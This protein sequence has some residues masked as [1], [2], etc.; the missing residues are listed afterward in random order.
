MKEFIKLTS[1]HSVIGIPYYSTGKLPKAE[2]AVLV[3]V[4]LPNLT[5]CISA[6]YC[7]VA[8]DASNPKFDPM[9]LEKHWPLIQSHAAETLGRWVCQQSSCRTINT[10]FVFIIINSYTCS[11]AMLH[12]GIPQHRHGFFTL[13]HEVRLSAMYTLVCIRSDLKYTLCK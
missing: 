7:L 3:F 10:D 1:P 8:Y 4:H 13:A 6:Q 12:L 2:S 9:V 11:L 5:T